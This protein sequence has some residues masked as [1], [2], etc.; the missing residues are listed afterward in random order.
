M[1]ASTISV[2]WHDEGQPIYTADFQP[3]SVAAG[4]VGAKLSPRLATGGGDNNVRVRENNLIL[5]YCYLTN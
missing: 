5:I 3:L 1:N 2:H 4:S